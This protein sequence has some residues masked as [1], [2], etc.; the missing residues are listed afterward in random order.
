[1]EFIS[2]DIKFS[3]NN[4]RTSSNIPRSDSSTCGKKG[5]F[6]C[7]CSLFA[8]YASFVAMLHMTAATSQIHVLELFTY[9]KQQFWTGQEEIVRSPSQLQRAFQDLLGSFC[10]R[11]LW[12][13]SIFRGSSETTNCWIYPYQGEEMNPW[14]FRNWSRDFWLLVKLVHHKKPIS[15]SWVAIHL[16]N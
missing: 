11:R 5:I 16:V 6:P 3:C 8:K 1:M 14:P 4:F 2:C 9:A 7:E 15:C 13:D 10:I 12:A